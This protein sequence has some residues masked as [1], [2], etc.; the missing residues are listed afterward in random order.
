M[1]VR[2][3]LLRYVLQLVSNT[4]MIFYLHYC[5]AC[6]KIMEKLEITI[7]YISF[8]FKDDFV[9]SVQ[10]LQMNTIAYWLNLEHLR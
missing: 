6:R 10:G 3:V 5:S 8:S 9:T 1:L 4:N 7:L 2:S